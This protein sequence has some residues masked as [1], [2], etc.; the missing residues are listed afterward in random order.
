[1]RNAKGTYA[2]NCGSSLIDFRSIGGIPTG[3]SQHSCSGRS[4]IFRIGLPMDDYSLGA[5]NQRL[6]K[7]VPRSSSYD[8]HW[9]IANVMGPHVLWLAEWLSQRLELTP[10]M[11]VL[12][13]GCGKALSS[14]FL[15]KE[16]GVSVWPQIIGSSPTKAWNESNGRGSRTAYS[17]CQSKHTR[18]PSQKGVS[19]RS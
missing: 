9:L 19:T 5:F 4:R 18:Y 3:P 17:R 11:R 10:G 1:M 16:F 13:L 12:D 15:A 2:E 14:I 6:F 8:P 7:P